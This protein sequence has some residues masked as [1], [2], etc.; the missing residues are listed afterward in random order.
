M[1]FAAWPVKITGPRLPRPAKLAANLAG[2]LWVKDK[3]CYN[4]IAIGASGI[5]L[6]KEE[7][8]SK[9]KH[10]LPE[11][12][13][14]NRYHI[15]LWTGKEGTDKPMKLHYPLRGPL[16]EIRSLENLRDRLKVDKG[17]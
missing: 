4:D 9:N 3:G 1:E 12:S 14:N 8:M 2:L 10:D 15:S 11:W 16:T 17:Y 5:L 7:P 6:V 13:P